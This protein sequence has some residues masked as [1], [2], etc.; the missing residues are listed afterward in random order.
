MH[1]YSK[2]VERATAR[3][4][5]FEEEVEARV[6]APEPEVRVIAP[7]KPSQS[8]MMMRVV[9]GSAAPEAKK[10]FKVLKRPVAQKVLGVTSVG[11]AALLLGGNS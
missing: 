10:A 8:D 5:P 1:D 6:S 7:P 2:A 4:L 11:V 3:T 9:F